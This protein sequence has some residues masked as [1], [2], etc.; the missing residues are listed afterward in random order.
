MIRITVEILPY[1]FEANKRTV[2]VMKIWNDITGT[3]SKGNYKFTISQ[4]QDLNAVWRGGEVKGFH[5]LSKS[6]WSLL[7]LCLCEIFLE[8]EKKK[9]DSVEES[10]TDQDGKQLQ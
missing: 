10:R 4:K 3:K 8:E 7:F 9:D 5:R 6:V 2:G 1:G